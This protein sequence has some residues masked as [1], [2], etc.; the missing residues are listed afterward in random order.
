MNRLSDEELRLRNYLLGGLDERDREQVE[1]QQLCDDGFAERLSVAQDNLIDDYVFD[2]LSKSERESFE[3]NFH[4]SAERRKKLLFAQ[5][6]E[7]YVEDQN[8]HQFSPSWRNPLLFLRTHKAGSAI[9]LA[10][11]LLLLF[12]TPKVMRQLRPIG[13]A[14]LP[15]AQRANIEQQIA[16][17]NKRPADPRIQALPAYELSLQPTLLREDKGIT[18]V[19]LTEEIKLLILKLA[20]PQV[21]HETYRALVLTVEG[22]ELFAIDGLTSE[23][24]AGAATVLLK[25]PSKFLSTGDYQIQL[26]GGTAGGN[27][28]NAVR[29][30]FRV[31]NKK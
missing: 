8:A 9:S 18:R 23:I 3:K 30:N 2:A 4:L 12:I 29:Y 15:L 28:E 21:Q 13:E 10:I 14:V 25:I 19:V 1:E 26:R 6:M 31:I 17:L 5:T 24:D 7:I 16:A 22:K 11:V 20:L 27:A